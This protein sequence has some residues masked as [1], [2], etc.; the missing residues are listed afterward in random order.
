MVTESEAKYTI[1]IHSASCVHQK[2]KREENRRIFIFFLAGICHKFDAYSVTVCHVQFAICAKNE[3]KCATYKHTPF[4]RYSRLTATLLLNGRFYF[5]FISFLKLIRS[6][7]HF[8]FFFL[9]QTRCRPFRWNYIIIK[10]CSRAHTCTHAHATIHS[11]MT[12]VINKNENKKKLVYAVNCLSSSQTLINS[13]CAAQMAFHVSTR[14]QNQFKW[15]CHKESNVGVG[16][17]VVVRCT[18]ICWNQKKNIYH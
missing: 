10:M 15:L 6:V 16:I 7:F 8:S 14:N 2:K 4:A 11:A 13:K 1:P 18:R 17:A 9:L 3:W 12:W 5:L